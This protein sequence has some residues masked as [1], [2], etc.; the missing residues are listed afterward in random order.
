M[1][2]ACLKIT[3]ECLYI[4][5]F[6]FQKSVIEKRAENNEKASIVYIL[7]N[8]KS[9]VAHFKSKCY[10]KIQYNKFSEIN[11]TLSSYKIE[12]NQTITI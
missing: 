11:L 1:Q 2:I 12:D 9:S 8:R 3:K 4:Y 5:I 6:F 10:K 7:L